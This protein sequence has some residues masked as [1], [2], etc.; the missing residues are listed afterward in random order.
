[1]NENPVVMENDG[2]DVKGSELFALLP[3]STDAFEVTYKDN[4]NYTEFY[5]AVYEAR[6]DGDPF[7][8]RFGSYQIY[9]A[10]KA[11]GQYQFI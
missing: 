9:Q 3:N 10:N 1:M 8:Y 2:N 4:L 11:N 7:P 6:N 5:E